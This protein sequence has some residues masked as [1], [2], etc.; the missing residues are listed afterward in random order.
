MQT[1]Y[2]AGVKLT[3]S[4]SNPTSNKEIKHQIKQQATKNTSSMGFGQVEQGRCLFGEKA[5]VSV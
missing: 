3:T 5:I 4:D 1:S 2:K